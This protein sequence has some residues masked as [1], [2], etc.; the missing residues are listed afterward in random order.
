[1]YIIYTFNPLDM[2]ARALISPEDFKAPLTF[3]A[4]QVSFLGASQAGEVAPQFWFTDWERNP[5]L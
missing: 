2:S 3:L 1:M 4:A 5:E